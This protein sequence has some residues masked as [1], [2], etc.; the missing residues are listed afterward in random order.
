MDYP[1]PAGPQSIPQNLT[2]PTSAYK[3]HAWL[4]MLLLCTFVAAYLALSGWFVWTAYR[5]FAGALKGGD[6][7]FFAAISGACA[8][9]LA[10]FML[11]ALFFV[12]RGVELGDIEITRQQE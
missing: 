12:R 6:D 10:V 4:A 9:F 11:K 5:M 3:R 2:A 7:A 8:A 1:Y